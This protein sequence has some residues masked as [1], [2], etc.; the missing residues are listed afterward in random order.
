MLRLFTKKNICFLCIAVFIHFSA[1]AVSL[2]PLSA[3]LHARYKKY[4]V[5]L[6]PDA[7]ETLYNVRSVIE[8]SGM[9]SDK[10]LA[11]LASEISHDFGTLLSENIYILSFIALYVIIESEDETLIYPLI[12]DINKINYNLNITN[13][14]FKDSKLDMENFRSEVEEKSDIF[15]FM[16]E[17]EMKNTDLFIEYNTLKGEL[18]RLNDQQGKVLKLYKYYMERRSFLI[19]V[20]NLCVEKLDYM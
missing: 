19:E 6:S 12:G 1:Y 16:R 4:L 7:E 3:S 18:M 5:F 8:F 20:L 14:K 15:N 2:E 9:S 10:M 17:D 13:K 11:K